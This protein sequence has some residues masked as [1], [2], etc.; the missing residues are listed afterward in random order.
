M[1]LK[2]WFRGVCALA[3]IALLSLG[4]A[5]ALREAAVAIG[6]VLGLLP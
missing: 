3:L 1:H 5:T 6:A 2:K 4:A